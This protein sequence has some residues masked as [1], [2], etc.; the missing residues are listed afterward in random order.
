MALR[1]EIIDR[2]TPMLLPTDLREWV[3]ENH[4]VHFIIDAVKGLPLE[5]YCLNHKGSGSKQY[6]PEMMLSLLIYCYVTRRFSSR[7]IEEAT[8]SDVVVRYICANTHPDHDTICS[9]RKRNDQAFKKAFVDV[10]ELASSVKKLKQVGTV[11]LDGTKIKANASKHAAVS[12]LKA[13][14]QLELLKKEVEELNAMA[15]AADSHEQATGLDIPHEIVR[16][17]DRIKKLDK[18]R[19]IIKE[20]H[21]E[22]Q[23]LIDAEKETEEVPKKDPPKDPPKEPPKKPEEVPPQNQYNFTDPESRI[24]KAGNGK[25]FVQAYN[26][27]VVVDTASMLI[28]G[29]HVTNAPTDKEQLIPTVE[30]IP[31]EINYIV[32]NVLADSG[33]YSEKAVSTVEA[34]NGPTVYAA[35]GRQSH[36]KS[37]QDLKDALNC[38]ESEEE[39][40]TFQEKMA[41]RLKTSRGRDLYKLRKQTVEPVF[42]IIKAAMGFRHFLTRGLTSVGT[43]WNLIT[44]AYNCKRLFNMLQA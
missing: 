35:V 42:G 31:N 5:A 34:N 21:L 28:L 41:A 44:L 10:L 11:S 19:E 3:P 2:E 14:E 24:M 9:F 32:E 39:G 43:E 12:Y 29:K 33:Y 20:R 6:S 16:R 38:S 1:L 15:K 27:Q 8:Y 25:H 37:V 23:A 13:G 36:H 22:K 26:A 7:I 4:I 30:S 40:R 17:E 18:A